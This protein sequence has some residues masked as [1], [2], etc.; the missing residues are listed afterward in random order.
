MKDGGHTELVR[1][2]VRTPKLWG[3]GGVHRFPGR[4]VSALPASVGSPAGAEG[5]GTR[6][7]PSIGDGAAAELFPCV[8]RNSIPFTLQYR[9]FL[10]VDMRI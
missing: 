9:S 6:H 5:W 8:T 7:S 4:A 1:S 2:T 10:L 3:G